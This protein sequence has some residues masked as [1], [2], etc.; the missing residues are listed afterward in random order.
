MMK[1]LPITTKMVAVSSAAL[2]T[3]LAVGIAGIGWQAQG[4][5]HDLSVNEVEAVAETQVAQV[6]LSLE[7]GLVASRGMAFAFDGLKRSGSTDR[8]AWTNVIEDTMVKNSNLSGTWGVILNDALDGKDKDFANTDMHDETGEWRPYHYRNADGSFGARPTGPVTN[9]EK[10]ADWFNGPYKS[11]KDYMT[12]PY[13]W[14]M[15]GNMVVG[16]SIGTPIRDGSKTIGVAGIDLTLTELS[17]RLAEV[18]PLGTGS[19]HLISQGGKWVAHPDGSL[20]GKEWKEGR[21]EQ[22][23]VFASQV[24]DAIKN[25]RSFSY[26]GY[27]KSLG[28]DVLRLIKP[29]KIG[30]TGASMALVVNVPI[31]TLDAASWQLVT[32]V[33]L[34]GLVLMIAV[35]LA[36]FIVGQ[37][38][39]R[40][41]LETT[42][43]SI[44]HLVNR[45]YEAPIS[46]T[47]RSDEIG[48]INKALEVF[49]EKARQAE[50]LTVGQE[51]EQRE[52]LQRAEQ[53]RGLTVDFEQQITALLDMVGNSVNDLNQTSTVL[54]KGADS[55]AHQSNAVAAASEEAS[56]NVET[57]A[58]AA[59][60]LFASVNEI[61]RQVEQSN[62]IAANAV[63]QARQ[64]NDKIEGLS[65]A[66]SRIG[67]VVKLITES[68]GIECHYRSGACG[69]SGQGFCCCGSRGEGIGQPNVQGNR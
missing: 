42:I 41:P 1:K 38:M 12:E 65:S 57:V 13:T 16:V 35:G 11:G 67:E 62:Q 18:K 44:K 5:T 23:L 7:E 54:T 9:P 22:D 30:D 8:L 48:E 45:N 19:V 33:A 14:E 24:M 39:I 60:E 25:G 51:Q 32:T 28:T 29:A 68:V 10:P 55:T 49:R 66:A 50:E 21:S 27:S 34:V 40:K 63:T 46:Y 58:S 47:D 3:V 26:H 52:R 59:E 17:K 36:L 15:A 56:S 64:T 31:D 20:L 6:R 61:D 43:G 69:R 53:I 2:A 37:H 4:I